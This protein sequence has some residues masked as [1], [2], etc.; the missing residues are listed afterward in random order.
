MMSTPCSAVGQGLRLKKQG[1]GRVHAGSMHFTAWQPTVPG[2][3][4]AKMQV[5][6]CQVSASAPL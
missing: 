6:P 4:H 5:Q 3:Q 1:E 2:A